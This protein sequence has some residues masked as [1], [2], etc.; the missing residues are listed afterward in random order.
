MTLIS[1]IFTNASQS[2]RNFLQTMII[3][4]Y[5][6]C[7]GLE[8]LPVEVFDLI[9]SFL[10]QT[11]LTVLCLL[12][13]KCHALAIPCLFRILDIEVGKFTKFL[14]LWQDGGIPAEHFQYVRRFTIRGHLHS[15]EDIQGYIHP[16]W[17]MLVDLIKSGIM[18]GLVTVAVDGQS[19]LGFQECK[20]HQP[21]LCCSL[22][23]MVCFG[24][25]SLSLLLCMA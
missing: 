14:Q 13:R 2:P 8:T 3:K 22:V 10:S 16:H 7:A 11:D 4:P 9:S 24:E 15:S 21:L 20:S 18:T 1:F 6:H 23:L 25:L 12:S 5:S 17:K 19:P